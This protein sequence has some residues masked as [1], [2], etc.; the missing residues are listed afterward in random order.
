MFYR[1]AFPQYTTRQ[2]PTPLTNPRP[3]MR[4]KTIPAIVIKETWTHDFFL[5]ASQNAEKAPNLA[6][7]NALLQAGMGKKHIVFKDKQGS[8]AH[9]KETLVREFPKLK[10]QNGAFE[11]MSQQRGQKSCL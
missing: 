6:E 11:F 10:T 8:F 4:V 5:L 1:A 7:S 2:N 3:R 9:I